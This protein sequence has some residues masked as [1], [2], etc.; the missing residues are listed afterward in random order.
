MMTYWEH[1]KPG[2]EIKEDGDMLISFGHFEREA[3][4]GHCLPVKDSESV[5]CFSG[6][7]RLVKY[8]PTGRQALR[9]SGADSL[10]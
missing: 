2:A 6:G 1:V 10:G 9:Q 4:S 8:S 7:P 3:H 5:T